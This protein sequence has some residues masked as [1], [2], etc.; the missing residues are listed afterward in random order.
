MTKQIGLSTASINR[1]LL[2]NN[3]SDHRPVRSRSIEI[4]KSCC[5]RDATACLH[6]SELLSSELS[7]ILCTSQS[8]SLSIKPT[9]NNI[10]STC[11][12]SLPARLT[13]APSAPCRIQAAG[14]PYVISRKNHSPSF[15]QHCRRLGH[16]HANPTSCRNSEQP[17]RSSCRRHLLSAQLRG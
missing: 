2:P 17:H 13:K 10:T 6:P 15:A 9:N 11:A 1:D 3:Q 12:C 16:G 5:A 8:S 14:G 4:I 7:I